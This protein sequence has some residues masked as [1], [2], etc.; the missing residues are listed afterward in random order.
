MCRYVRY[1][2]LKG[3]I[4]EK[5]IDLYRDKAQSM[6]NVN[7]LLDRG[8]LVLTSNNYQDLICSLIKDKNLDHAC[9][10]LMIIQECFW[11]TFPLDQT[12]IIYAD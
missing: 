8:D 6:D 7:H 2:V 12:L 3:D 4:E 5:N 9:G 10:L 11:G 1:V